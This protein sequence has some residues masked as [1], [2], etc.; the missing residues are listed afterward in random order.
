V[1][2]QDSQVNG[3]DA[4]SAIHILHEE[5]KATFGNCSVKRAH[6]PLVTVA[7]G[8]FAE[9]LDCKLLESVSSV[10]I[11]VFGGG[12]RMEAERCCFERSSRWA[13]HVHSGARTVV[14]VPRLCPSGQLLFK[15]LS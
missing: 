4:E 2:V 15:L 7:E 13:L 5:T 11:E 9:F 14:F 1:R 10:G 6:G 12:S 8:A 3:T